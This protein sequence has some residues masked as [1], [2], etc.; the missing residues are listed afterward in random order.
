M[1]TMLQSKMMQRNVDN[2]FK[3]L[4]NL[5]YHLKREYFAKGKD[6]AKLDGYNLY[7]SL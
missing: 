3:E 4:K 6:E 2:V 1:E 5:P 7:F